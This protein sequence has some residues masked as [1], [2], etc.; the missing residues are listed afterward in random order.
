MATDRLTT[1]ELK[2]LRSV[3]FSTK[4]GY[5]NAED[6]L[7]DEVGEVGSKEREEFDAKARAWY[8]GELLRDRR[9]ELGMTQKELAERVGRERTY[10]NRIEKGETDLQLSSFIRI[11]DALGF[12]LK[13]ETPMVSGYGLIANNTG[14]KYLSDVESISYGKKKKASR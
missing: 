3:D 14:H 10:I 9:K 13:L 4:P 1:E 12:T 2:R 8:F 11:A 7:S 5:V 6:V